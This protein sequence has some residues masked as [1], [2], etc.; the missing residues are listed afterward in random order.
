MAHEETAHGGSADR[1]TAHGGTADASAAGGAATGS[2][3]DP[4]SGRQDGSGGELERLRAEVQEL[5][6]RVSTRKQRR[7]RL[8]AV[9]RVVA[10]VV[11]ALVAV[12]T[13]TSVVGV[14][15]ARTALNTDRWVATVG[16][17]PE[18]PTVDA[19]VA[20]YLT[21]EIFNQLDVEQRL[22]GALPPRASFIAPPVTDAVHDY[23]R[24]SVAKL[25]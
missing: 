12:L 16:A 23:M 13:V 8:L 6:A 2:E 4:E 17:L 10:A 24:D 20:A 11:I 14:W 22:S 25:L 5:R 15:G 3:R 7:I 1:G 19:A 18:D 9:R 21:D